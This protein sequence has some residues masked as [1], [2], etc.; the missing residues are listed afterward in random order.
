MILGQVHDNADQAPCFL[1]VRL[2]WL[3]CRFPKGLNAIGL[4]V[5]VKE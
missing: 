4:E 3:E 2:T 5:L 1:E